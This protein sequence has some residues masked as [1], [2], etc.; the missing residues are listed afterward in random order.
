MPTYQLLHQHQPDE[1]RFAYAAW[2]GFSSPLRH[3]AALSSCA[4][5]GHRIWWTVEADGP[6][7]ALSLLPSYLA[8]RCEVDPVSEVPI[9]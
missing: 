1:C 6:E 2:N 8:A 7:A 3:Q 4:R 9:P 5:G